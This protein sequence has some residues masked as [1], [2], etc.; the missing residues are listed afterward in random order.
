MARGMAAGTPFSLAH[1]FLQTG[2]FR[3]SN[4]ERRRPGVFLAGTGTTPGVGIPMVL[5]SGDLAARR[6]RHYLGFPA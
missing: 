3:P 2:P 6:V 4:V 5:I 1:S